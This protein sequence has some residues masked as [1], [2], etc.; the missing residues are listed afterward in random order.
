M[1]ME[2]SLLDIPLTCTTFANI[3]LFLFSDV[4]ISDAHPVALLYSYRIRMHGSVKYDGPQ[5]PSL[6]LQTPNFCGNMRILSLPWQRGSV[7][8]MFQ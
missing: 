5:S 4:L 3:S 6:V 2:L 1:S 8:G 7:G